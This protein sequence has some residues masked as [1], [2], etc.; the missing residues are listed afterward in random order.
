MSHATPEYDVE[1]T[2]NGNQAAKIASIASDPKGPLQVSHHD[3]VDEQP[4]TPEAEYD[5]IQQILAEAPDADMLEDD[6][7]AMRSKHNPETVALEGGPE[8]N[9][10]S[11]P[12][13]L[14]SGPLFSAAFR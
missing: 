1:Y 6:M 8:K 12:N 7:D 11:S 2:V 10:P 14:S 3:T 4:K 13:G 5:I 9:R